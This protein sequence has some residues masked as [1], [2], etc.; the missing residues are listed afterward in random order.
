MMVFKYLRGIFWI[1]EKI[2]QGI[3][4]CDWKQVKE[5]HLKS[6]SHSCENVS[7]KSLIKMVS[8]SNDY[9]LAK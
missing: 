9:S 5:N 1:K 6:D 2:F 4:F 7:H 8:R 3:I